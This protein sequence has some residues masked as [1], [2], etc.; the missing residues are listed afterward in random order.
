MLFVGREN[1]EAEAIVAIWRST[2]SADE[3]VVK[4][5]FVRGADDFMGSGWQKLLKGDQEIRQ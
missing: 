3:E 4:F 1:P 2:H 5:W